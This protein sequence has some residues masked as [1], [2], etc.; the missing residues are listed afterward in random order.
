VNKLKRSIAEIYWKIFKPKTFGVR[1]LIIDKNK[2]LLVK[3]TY[4]PE[5]YLPGG[6]IKI[7]ESFKNVLKRELYEELG[8][9]PENIKL[10]GKYTNIKEGKRD[11]IRVYLV[12]Q[13]IDINKL[14]PD[15][16]EIVEIKLFN[17][18]QLSKDISP[19]SLR[20]INEYNSELFPLKATW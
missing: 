9:Y 16:K 14:K 7:K 4:L 8:L 10:F 6:G 18:D 2:V 19:G 1:A 12:K 3:H 17:L 20:R 11:T 13:K 15:K 5:W